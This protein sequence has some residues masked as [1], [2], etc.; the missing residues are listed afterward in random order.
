MEIKKLT[1]EEMRATEVG[2][3]KEIEIETRLELNK[4]RM[5][6]YGKGAATRNT[7][8]ILKKNL[9][10]VLTIKTEAKTNAKMKTTKRGKS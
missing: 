3:L 2:R 7:K 9:A 5:D 1:A 6:V 10:R 8:K 4:M